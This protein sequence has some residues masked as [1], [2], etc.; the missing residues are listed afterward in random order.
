MFICTVTLGI[1]SESR[2][3]ARSCDKNIVKW[4]GVARVA[5][6]NGYIDHLVYVYTPS[7][8]PWISSVNRGLK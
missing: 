7:F 6:R 5:H 4:P 3:Y 1:G 2:H 8:C